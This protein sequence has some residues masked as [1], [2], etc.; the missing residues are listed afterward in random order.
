VRRLP[1]SATCR[2]GAR[3]AGDGRSHRDALVVGA[4]LLVDESSDCALPSCRFS[5]AISGHGLGSAVHRLVPCF[6][7]GS[8]SVGGGAPRGWSTEVGAVQ[9]CEAMLRQPLGQRG[10]PLLRGF[11]GGRSWA[12]DRL[13]RR[14][15]CGYVFAWVSTHQFRVGS[16]RAGTGLSSIGLR[17]VARHPNNCQL[18]CAAGWVSARRRSSPAVVAPARC[19]IWIESDIWTDCDVHPNSTVVSPGSDVP[20][21]GLPTDGQE[22]PPDLS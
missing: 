19:D 16:P 5:D 9:T 17:P 11:H 7:R 2:L 22:S 13:G 8:S 18:Q 6:G 14:I 1:G 4:N 21:P 20:D 10:H 3:S 15:G 12:F